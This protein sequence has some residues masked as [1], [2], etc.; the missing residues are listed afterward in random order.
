MYG[1]NRNITEEIKN[2]KKIQKEILELK[3][4]SETQKDPV[5]GFKS[6]FK[7]AEERISKLEDKTIEMSKSEEQKEKSEGT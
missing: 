5:E 7:H 1:H 2:I 3:S 6:R 4:I